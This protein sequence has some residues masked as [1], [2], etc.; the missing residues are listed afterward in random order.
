MNDCSGQGSIASDAA[1]RVRS[2]VAA[3]ESEAARIRYEAE[4]DAQNHLRGAEEQSIRFLDDAKRQA[5]G[6]VEERR[7]RIEELSGRI[8]G[9]S[10]ALLERIDNA[11][12]VRLQLDALVHALGETADRA[13]RDSGAGSAEHFQAPLRTSPAPTY[14]PPP[15]ASPP[16][17]KDQ[18][19]GSRLVALQ[20]AVAGT[21]REEVEVH[22]RRA[23]GLDDPAPI[24]DDVFGSRTGGRRSDTRRR[25][26][27]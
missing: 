4:R 12:A 23:F 19:D 18:F 14:E 25:A 15:A 11:D 22:L 9:S 16:A 20:M 27:G 8:V 3:A 5:E 10:E 26:A 21:G 1:E 7:R 24:L 13:T 6:L 17:P 2:I